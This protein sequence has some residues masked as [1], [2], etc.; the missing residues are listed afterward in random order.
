M[1]VSMNPEVVFLLK[2]CDVNGGDIHSTCAQ[3]LHQQ[4]VVP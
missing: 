2:G 3:D 1:S 4:C